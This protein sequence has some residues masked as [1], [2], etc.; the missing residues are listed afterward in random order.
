[1][2]R[3]CLTRTDNTRSNVLSGVATLLLRKSTRFHDKKNTTVGSQKEHRDYKSKFTHSENAQ[4]MC[5]NTNQRH[6]AIHWKPETKKTGMTATL[7][8]LHRLLKPLRDDQMTLQLFNSKH[9]IL[10]CV[11]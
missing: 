3:Q 10:S 8:C 11:I 2:V 6:C 4:K 7:V 5:C 1:M 9:I